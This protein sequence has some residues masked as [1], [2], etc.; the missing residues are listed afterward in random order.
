MQHGI[1][2]WGGLIWTTGG[3]IEFLKSSYF[4]LIWAFKPSVK[5]V[6]VPE[7]NLPQNTVRLTDTNGGTATLNRVPETKDIKMLGVFKAAALDNHDE[8]KYLLERATLY[9][10]A[11][12]ACPLQPHETWL[13][14]DTV[15]MQCVTYPL[16]AT[17]L[18]LSD[19][20]V[21]KLHTAIIP[22]VLPLMGYTRTFP[23]TII[24]VLSTQ[25]D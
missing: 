9:A 7:N 5:P 2:I 10:S 3:M 6:I 11:S 13:G 24:L 16:S 21:K 1:A 20:Q 17:S 22:C 25:E 18:S 14:Y 12:Y 23:Y 19:D 4:L 15:Y 8:Y